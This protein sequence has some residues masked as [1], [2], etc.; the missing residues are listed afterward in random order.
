MFKNLTAFQIDIPNTSDFL[1]SLNGKLSKYQHAPLGEFELKNAGWAP[2]REEGDLFYEYQ[3]YALLNLAVEKRSVPKSVIVK[4]V[5][6]LA[7]DFENENGYAPG[8]KQV[9]K[10]AEEALELLIPRAFP[11]T[12]Y[13]RV[14]LDLKKGLVLVDSVSTPVVDE[15]VKALLKTDDTIQ[16]TSLDFAVSAAYLMAR[17]LPDGPPTGITIDDSA[18][19]VGADKRTVTLKNVNVGSGSVEISNTTP[20]AVAELIQN[21]MPPSA[22]AI[23]INDDLSAVFTA[24]AGLKS[25]K[26]NNLPTEAPSDSD[27]F[28]TDLYLNGTLLSKAVKFL[29][30]CAN[31]RDLI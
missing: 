1:S 17:W 5:K 11:I 24:D 20:I 29:H 23:T 3:S 22:L 6:E 18:V 19:F 26:F 9:K 8:R 15:V 2:I 13:T 7:A 16:L 25:I 30:A 14:I 27:T 31:N 4:K 28:D 21:G 10:L 12:K